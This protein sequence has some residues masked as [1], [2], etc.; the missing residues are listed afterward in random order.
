MLNKDGIICLKKTLE[1]KNMF[2][3][4]IWRMVEYFLTWPRINVAMEGLFSIIY[5]LRANEKKSFS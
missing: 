2:I 3:E 4:N 5:V 1:N